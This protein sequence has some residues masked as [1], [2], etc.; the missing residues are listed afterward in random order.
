MTWKPVLVIAAIIL[1]LL[2]LVGAAFLTAAA[3]YF[4]AV[5]CLGIA[6]FVP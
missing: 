1:A 6:F 2:P 4:L 3:C 5:L